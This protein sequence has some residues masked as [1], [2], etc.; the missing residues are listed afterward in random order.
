MKVNEIDEGVMYIGMENI[1]SNIGELVSTDSKDSISSASVFLKNDILFPKLH[2]YLNKVYYANEEG[3][4]STEFH[5]FYSDNQCNEFIANFLRSKV[6]VAQTKYLMSGNTL[7]RL[8]LEDIEKLL[9]PIPPL[10]K[11]IEIVDHITKIRDRAKQLRQEAVAELEKAKQEV[12]AMIL[13][14][15]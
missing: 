10:E 12:E 7:P 14:A 1:V 5:V 6:I 4:C 3:I 15:E 8:Q 11:Q 9:I 13:G 2:P